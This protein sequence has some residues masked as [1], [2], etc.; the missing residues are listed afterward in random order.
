MY[1]NI[2]MTK[3]NILEKFLNKL[4]DKDLILCITHDNHIHM[5][6]FSGLFENLHKKKAKIIPKRFVDANKFFDKSIIH[7]YINI[8]HKIQ[9][10]TDIIIDKSQMISNKQ[11]N[12]VIC[13]SDNASY[14]QIQSEFSKWV[15][16]YFDGSKIHEK[17]VK[18]LHIVK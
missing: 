18:R 14:H 4:F 17:T 1:N 10:Q 5:K 7:Y 8:S 13:Y 3:I 16:K 2:I 9:N 6:N 11:I 12:I 15:M